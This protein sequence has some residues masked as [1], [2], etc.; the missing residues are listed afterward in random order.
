M[1]IYISFNLQAEVLKNCSLVPR[2]SKLSVTCCM[3]KWREPATFFL[4]E[5][6]IIRKWQKVNKHAGCVSRIVQIHCTVKTWCEQQ[7]LLASSICVVSY[8]DPWLFLLFWAQCTHTQLNPF[9]YSFCSDVTYMRKTPSPLMLFCTASW[10]GSGT[11]AK[12]I[13]GFILIS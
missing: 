5:H 4:D 10:A 11:V 1:H 7:S 3:K 9:C 8:Q 13:E 12:I 6:N 2:P